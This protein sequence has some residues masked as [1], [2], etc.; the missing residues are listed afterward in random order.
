M[1]VKILQKCKTKL[2]QIIKDE[3]EKFIPTY[4]LSTESINTFG[5][6]PK[7]FLFM[8]AMPQAFQVHT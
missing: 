2:Y 3:L 5:K 7:C 6:I 4:A 8:G 1:T